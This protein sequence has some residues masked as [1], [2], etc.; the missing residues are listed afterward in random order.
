MMRK[1]L[2]TTYWNAADVQLVLEFLEELHEIIRSGYNEELDALYESYR[3]EA[4]TRTE[5]L[6]L[7]NDDIPF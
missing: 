4:G 2:L 7:F 1:M 3:A 6:D 5:N